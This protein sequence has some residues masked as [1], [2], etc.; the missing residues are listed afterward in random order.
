MGIARRAN[1]TW[2]LIEPI[3]ITAGSRGRRTLSDRAMF[4]VSRLTRASNP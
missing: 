2:R 4:L 3:G 1:A